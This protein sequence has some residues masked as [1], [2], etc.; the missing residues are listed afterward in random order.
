MGGSRNHHESRFHPC[1]ILSWHS[2]ETLLFHFLSA[3]QVFEGPE[4]ST[5]PRKGREAHTREQPGTG[6]EELPRDPSSG[7]DPSRCRSYPSGGSSCPAF[8]KAFLFPFF[9]FVNSQIFPTLPL[10][11]L[12]L[13]GVHSPHDQGFRAMQLMFYPGLSRRRNHAA[14]DHRTWGKERTP[15]AQVQVSNG[16]QLISGRIN[17]I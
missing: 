14:Q 4:A 6:G 2:S 17:P 16:F 13:S 1:E 7:E 12:F 15:Q 3:E 11:G 8:S 9:I 5:Q 10:S